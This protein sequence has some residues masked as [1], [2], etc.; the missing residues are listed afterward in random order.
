MKARVLCLL[1]ALLA[2][3]PRAEAASDGDVAQAKVFFKAGAAAYTAGD[4]LAAIQALEA[5]YQLT[6]LPA[7]A[8]SL[9]QAER[10]QYFVSRERGHLQRA[11]VLYRIYLSEV[12]SGGRRADATDALAQLE[13]LALALGGAPV[14]PGSPESPET[15]SAARDPG[16]TR[17]LVT[18]EVPEASIS[19]DGA[20]P[21]PS[22]LIAEVTPG[23]HDV[24][25]EARGYFPAERGVVAVSGA[26]VPVEIPLRVR[27]ASV[28][29][30]ASADADLYIDGEHAG[31]VGQLV[32]LELPG[33]PHSFTFGK[34][35]HRLTTV[36]AELEPGESHVISAKLVPTSQRTAAYIMFASAGVSLGATVIF[37]VLAA[38]Q[39]EKARELQQKQESGN[40][41]A[42]ELEDYDEALE[43]R[44]EL[45]GAAVLSGLFFGGVL[46]TGICLHE[47]DHPNVQAVPSFDKGRRATGEP[48]RVSLLPGPG[49]AGAA[50]R[51]SF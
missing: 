45:R 13:P 31:K 29:L 41:T 38:G 5:A 33:G 28:S 20:K 21:V 14:A 16:K 9:A 2:R 7:I 50:V 19:L 17:L 8:F 25:V 18:S 30:R 12:Q 49:D 32:H 23:R 44:G 37:G 1:V 40:I 48:A 11:I 39:E 4:Y 27:P 51:L 10:R 24:K 22:P 34:K 15:P 3:A 47:F 26:L 6:P 46:V 36:Q 43:R 35:G 42:E